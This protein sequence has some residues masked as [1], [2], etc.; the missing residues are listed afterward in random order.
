[1]NSG[2][3]PGAP[4]GGPLLVVDDLS[5]EFGTDDGVVRAVRGVSF[6]LAPGEVLGIV[7]ESGCGKS[8][9]AAAIMGLLPR[10]STVR[11]SIRFEGEEMVGASDSV[12]R[13]LRG[14]RVSMI[15]QDPMTSLNPVYTVGWQLAEAYRAHHKSS[16]REARAKAVE[17]LDQVGIPQPDRRAH[18]YPHEFSGGMRQ[19]AMIAMAIINQPRLIIADEPTTALDVTVQA[20]ILETL[21]R[22]STDAGAAI[23]LITHDLGVVAGMA[24]RVQV[25]YGGTVVEAAGVEELFAHPRM[26]Y[27]VGLL[28]SV[29]HPEMVGRR[30]T[31][32]HGAPPSPLHL[33]PGCTFG[34]R[35]PLMREDPCMVSE[36][37]LVTVGGPADGAVDGV[38][39]GLVD[40]A[41]GGVVE[42]HAT[43]CHRWTELSGDQ[44]ARR[45]FSSAEIGLHEAPAADL[46]EE[47]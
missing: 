23:V 15:F 11:G 44:S 1:M 19:R 37:E 27:T 17:S 8:V 24:D 35:C 18:Q 16:A 36:P 4:V 47:Q 43:R 38:A 40:G 32:I 10:N 42:P 13:G 21:V 25:M 9:T 28:G 3:E 30:L 41:A 26:P 22:I 33:P 34:P 14:N 39:G 29:P 7:G 6:T 31:P 12:L 20:Q 46:V 5:V 2:R 45:M